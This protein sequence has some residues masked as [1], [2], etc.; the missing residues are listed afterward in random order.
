[1]QFNLT[2]QRQV[3]PDL[4]V[5]LGYIGSQT[6]HNT[7]NVN[8]NNMLP[9]GTF[10]GQKCWSVAGSPC[11]TTTFPARR[12]PNFS[13]VLQREFDTNANYNS[14]QF[15]VRKRYSRGL[16]VNAVYQLSRTMDEISGIGGSTD[17]DNITSFSM[18]PEDRGRDYS[19]AAFDIRPYMTINGS[20][21]LPDFGMTGLAERVLGGW[22][23]SS[24]L[25]YSSGEPLTVVNA[26]DR[27]GNNTRIFG[28]QERP[29]VAPGASNDPVEGVTAGCTL[30]SGSGARIVPA[31]QKLGT[32][33]LWFDPC[34]FRLQPAGLLGNLGR[35]TV[36]SP[37]LIGM[38]LGVL[39]NFPISESNRLEFR[40]ELFNLLNHPNFG[41]PSASLFSNATT[42][43]ATAATIT[44]TEG[45]ARQMQ[46]ALK[47]I[48]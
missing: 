29:D 41:G 46:F 18:D 11:F 10:N 20:Y 40:W 12:N 7:R 35:N 47:Y 36:Q 33:E 25:N 21:E 4:S 22:K 44:S 42:V 24:M 19:R 23:F 3:L 48:F 28:N 32:P 39:K 5:M 43:S 45:S 30:G 37:S 6:R 14:L 34:A 26:F 27:S 38:V 2:L 9:A 8:W 13:A 31:G 15:Q 1:M 17:F 16:D